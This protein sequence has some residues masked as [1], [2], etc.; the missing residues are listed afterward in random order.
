MFANRLV[1]SLF[2]TEH[3]KDLDTF[4]AA[5]DRPGV[6]PAGRH[7]RS[8]L[9]GTAAGDDSPAQL[10]GQTLQ[11][12]KGIGRREMTTALIGPPGCW[13]FKPEGLSRA[14]KTY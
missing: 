12:L 11:P 8:R 5:F 7:S 1:I 2:Q 13:P 9:H 14:V 6:L 10:F 3:L 4:L